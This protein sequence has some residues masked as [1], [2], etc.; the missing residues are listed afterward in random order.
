MAEEGADDLAKEETDEEQD[1]REEDEGVDGDGA[2]DAG[3]EEEEGDRG[4][5]K[6]AKKLPASRPGS[7]SARVHRRV[8][9][10]GGRRAGAAGAAGVAAVAGTRDSGVALIGRRVEVYWDGE[11]QVRLSKRLYTHFMYLYA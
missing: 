1:D 11:M 8:G 5:E 6:Y 4:R 7:E 9:A 2:E 3:A 10:G